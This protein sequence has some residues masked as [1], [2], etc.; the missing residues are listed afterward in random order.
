M[1]TLYERERENLW[2]KN[3]QLISKKILDALKLK[4]S[5][6]KILKLKLKCSQI[7]TN[8]VT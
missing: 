6:N 7:Q 2:D 1:Y 4:Q 5:W 8:A 3:Q